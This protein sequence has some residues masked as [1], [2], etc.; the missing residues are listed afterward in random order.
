MEVVST[1]VLYVANFMVNSLKSKI[2]L[3]GVSTG[4]LNKIPR[5]K[6]KKTGNLNL[7]DCFP[8]RNLQLNVYPH[9]D[10]LKRIFA[11]CSDN[12]YTYGVGLS[13][14]AVP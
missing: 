14:M 13:G 7:D 1:R 6:P 9:Y 8:S 4:M 10:E 2:E 5:G 3:S 12:T 11:K